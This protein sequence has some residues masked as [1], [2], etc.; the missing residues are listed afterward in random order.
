MYLVLKQG[1]IWLCV[2]A[3][4]W[5]K[6]SGQA[7]TFDPENDTIIDEVS[8]LSLAT[9]VAFYYDCNNTYYVVAEPGKNRTVVYDTNWNFVR[10]IGENGP[11]DQTLAEPWAVIIGPNNNVWIADQLNDRIVEFTIEGI[12][13]QYVV[14][15]NQFCEH[16]FNIYVIRCIVSLC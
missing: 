6:M 5:I 11:V 7:F 3:Y 12:L 14:A 8:G 9:S 16:L 13:L 10:S 2:N 15:K 1:G 4:S